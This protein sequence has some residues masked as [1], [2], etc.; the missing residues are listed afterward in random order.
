MPRAELLREL[1]LAGEEARSPEKITAQPA[2]VERVE[3][4]VKRVNGRLSAVERIRRVALRAEPFTV[5]NGLMTPTMK[6]RRAQIYREHAA[7]LEGLYG[8]R[9]RAPEPA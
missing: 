5:E 4:A 2:L 9:E 3:Q 7:L 6:L 8:P 1:G